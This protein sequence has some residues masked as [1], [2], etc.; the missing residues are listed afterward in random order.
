M[1]ALKT[2]RKCTPAFHAKLGLIKAETP[3][4]SGSQSKDV[5]L[6]ETF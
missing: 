6:T 3:G 1:P 4:F 5:G 2:S